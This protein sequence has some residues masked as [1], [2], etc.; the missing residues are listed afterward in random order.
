MADDEGQN[1]CQ[2]T[3]CLLIRHHCMWTGT[4][5]PLWRSVLMSLFTRYLWLN[6]FPLHCN[7]KLPLLL[8]HLDFDKPVSGHFLCKIVVRSNRGLFTVLFLIPEY[9]CW[10][11]L[12]YIK[13][14]V[15]VAYLPVWVSP[16]RCRWHKP[17][18]ACRSLKIFVVHQWCMATCYTFA[19]KSCLFLVTVNCYCFDHF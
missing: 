9:A 6:Y 2:V 14:S 4:L 12:T 13:T 11:V 16:N 5:L 1:P 18:V 10:C 8:L 19:W 3:C 7:N 17:A 15:Q